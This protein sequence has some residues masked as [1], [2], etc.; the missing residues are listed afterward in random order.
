MGI[1]TFFKMSHWNLV[2]F[3]F[4]VCLLVMGKETQKQVSWL[5]WLS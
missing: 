3:F 5:T 1:R 2:R 4:V